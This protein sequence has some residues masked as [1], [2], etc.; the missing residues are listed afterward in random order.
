MF[1]GQLNVPGPGQEA[2]GGIVKFQRMQSL[3]PNTPRG[4]NV[5]YMASSQLPPGA[6][7]LAKLAKARG[8]RFVWNQ[9]GVAYPAWYGPGWAAANWAPRQLLS[10]ADHVFYQS[11][12]CQVSADRYLTKARGSSDVLYNAVDT[13]L[14]RPA[15]PRPLADPLVLLLG[16]TQFQQHRATVALHVL[17]ALRRRGVNVRLIV[18]GRLAWRADETAARGELLGMA[19]GL[20]VRDQIELAGAYP[21]AAAPDLFRRAHLLLHPQYN[22]ASPGTVIEAMASGLPVVYSASGGVPEIVGDSA[23]IGLPCELRWDR[24]MTPDA[25]QMAAAVLEVSRRLD[26]YAAAA[27]E[28]AVEHFDLQPWLARHQMVFE[29]LV[30]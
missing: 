15:M 5:L 4:F 13:R 23:G 29:R 3:Y 24:I 22:D 9:N 30:G 1:Y 10:S 17:A 12:F 16:G 26:A 14:F 27:R 2:R 25:D 11:R 6:L 8:A 18:A 28:R 21:Q 20:G 7:L 19:E